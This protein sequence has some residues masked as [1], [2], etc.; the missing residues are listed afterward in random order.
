M[1]HNVSEN[2]A[3]QAME[4]ASRIPAIVYA[5][6]A[7]ELLVSTVAVPVALTNFYL[8][9]ST[10][11]IHINLKLL[12]L[13]QSVAIFLYALGR[14]PYSFIPLAFP[15][16]RAW[17]GSKVMMTALVFGQA[18]TIVNGDFLLLER[19]VATVMVSR[20]ENVRKPYLSAPA[21]VFTVLV[22]GLVTYQQVLSIEIQSVQLWTISA[23]YASSA[24]GFISFW[25]LLFLQY[26]NHKVY[27]RRIFSLNKHSLTER[28]Q[29]SEN[30][31]TSRQLT[32]VLLFHFLS[33]AVSGT[34]TMLL[35][36]K[37]QMHPKLISAVMQGTAFWMGFM[38][39]LTQVTVIRCHPIL[40][41][42]IRHALWK[43]KN[44][45]LCYRQIGVVGQQESQQVT[46]PQTI[47]GQA[48]I[49]PNE[50]EQDAYFRTLDSFWQR[51]Q[52]ML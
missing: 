2:V 14:I 49:N 37:V 22:A 30:I 24:I 51:R 47:T 27:R 4:S 9:A 39:L 20:Y 36:H 1:A 52:T 15:Q 38:N 16:L 40:Y 26:Y 48:L 6:T 21:L 34:M 41:R 8:I 43:T 19:L 28:Y 12:L 25:A 23:T 18:S 44:A 11:L 45:V 50:N 33:N 3:L 35:Y 5:L 10:Q 32:P 7:A 31:R 42:R 13:L 17:P 29:L 46:P